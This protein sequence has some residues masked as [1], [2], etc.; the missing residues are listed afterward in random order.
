M[1]PVI[2]GGNETGVEVISVE[3]DGEVDWN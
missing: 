2:D 3:S 1:C